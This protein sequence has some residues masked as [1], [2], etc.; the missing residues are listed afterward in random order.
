MGSS[1]YVQTDTSI[2]AMETDISEA[3]KLKGGLLMSGAE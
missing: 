2:K 1:F 3:N